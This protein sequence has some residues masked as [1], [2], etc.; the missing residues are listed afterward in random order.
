MKPIKINITNPGNYGS[1]EI[2]GLYPCWPSEYIIW[3]NDENHNCHVWVDCW[4]GVEK[5][6]AQYKVAVLME[7]KSLCP[8]NY[9][10]VYNMLNIFDLVFTTYPEDIHLHTKYRY[11]QGGARSFIRPEERQVYE[12]SKNICAII[13][14]KNFLPGHNVRHSIK[15]KIQSIKPNLVDF[16]NP[17]MLNK[18]S[19]LKDYRFELVIENEDS[20]F[21]SEKLIDSMLAGCIPIYWTQHSSNYLNCF[22]LNGIITFQTPDELY[23]QLYDGIFNEELYQNKLKAI[24]YNFEKAKEYISFGDIL[25]NAGLGNLL[26]KI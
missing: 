23:Q 14:Q 18:V 9:D 4:D 20:K 19:G 6:T 26:N 21:F 15:N 10:I 7:P 24:Q 25:W 17:P 22:N 12:K 11:Y 3:N 8:Y 16:I 13:S 2:Q 1:E 5:S